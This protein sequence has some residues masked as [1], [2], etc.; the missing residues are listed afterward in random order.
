METIPDP[1]DPRPAKR[2]ACSGHA[3]A[4]ADIPSD[5]V[6]RAMSLVTQVG[7]DSCWPIKAK[8]PRRRPRIVFRDPQGQRREEQVARV[9]YVSS[10]GHLADGQVVRHQC[11][12]G[13]CGRPDHLT[14]G[15]QS[16]NGQD[17]RAFYRAAHGITPEIE[18]QIVVDLTA[19]HWGDSTAKTWAQRLGVPTGYIYRISRQ[20][21]LTR[22]VSVQGNT[23]RSQGGTS[24]PQEV[25]A[26]RAARC[27]PTRPRHS[28]PSSECRP[29]P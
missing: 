29:T 9:I 3:L 23:L 6:A 16:D 13:W 2:G 22:R 11:G 18:H 5:A 19:G 10:G 4:L 28:P 15:S 20:H 1:S 27:R 12:R 7:G 25:A 24:Q 26:P 8:N 17:E 21:G 14:N